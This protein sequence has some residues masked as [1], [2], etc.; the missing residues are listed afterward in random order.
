VVSRRVRARTS[1]DRVRQQL[2]GGRHRSD[3]AVLARPVALPVLEKLVVKGTTSA[4]RL[5]LARQ[6]AGLLADALPGR[7]IHVVADAA[8]AGKELRKLPGQVTWT[9]RLRKDAALHD[10]PPARTGCR[11]GPAPGAAG[12]RPWPGSPARTSPRSPSPAT[13]RPPP[14]MPPP[15]PA[16]RI[17]PSPPGPSRSSSSATA[18]PPATTT[19]PRA[20]GTALTLS[21]PPT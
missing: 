1:Q 16:C 4:S 17:L 21:H 8:Y 3:A 20:P 7:D 13:V 9:T 19:G 5:W 10:L 2:G 14:S 12:C 11:A 18:P 15:S 6:M